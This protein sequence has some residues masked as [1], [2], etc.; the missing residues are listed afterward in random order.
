MHDA[1]IVAITILCMLTALCIFFLMF[2]GVM[3]GKEAEDIPE[4]EYDIEEYDDK[5]I[6]DLEMELENLGG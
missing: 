1:K 4:T 3:D 6:R 5:L 2:M